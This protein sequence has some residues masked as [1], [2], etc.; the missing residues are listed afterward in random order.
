MGILFA[1]DKGSSTRKKIAQKGTD[2]SDA[3]GEKFNELVVGVTNQ[4]EA[5]KEGAA[6][7]VGNGKE[8]SKKMKAK[9]TTALS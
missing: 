9:I 4:L 5:V 6:H 7:M 3:A 1:P 2:Y 8:K